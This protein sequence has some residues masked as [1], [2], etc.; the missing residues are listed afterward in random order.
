MSVLN[1]LDSHKETFANRSMITLFDRLDK[2][3]GNGDHYI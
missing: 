2:I 1:A 3:N